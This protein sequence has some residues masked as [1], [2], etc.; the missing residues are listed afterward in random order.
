MN[1]LLPGRAPLPLWRRSLLVISAGI[2]LLV[3]LGGSVL[4][5]Q[6]CTDPAGGLE[7]VALALFYLWPFSMFVVWACGAAVV[8]ATRTG[9]T[10]GRGAAVLIWL[11]VCALALLGLTVTLVI[12][13]QLDV[14]RTIAAASALILVDAAVIYA[15]WRLIHSR[16]QTL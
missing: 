5:F 9:R 8:L 13:L 14:S 12:L 4:M 7:E 2:T 6:A 15:G 3:F 1:D 10:S 11:L 16:W